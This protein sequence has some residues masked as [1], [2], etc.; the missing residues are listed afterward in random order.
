MASNQPIYWW[1]W[2]LIHLA[3]NSRASHLHPAAIPKNG[4]ISRFLPKRPPCFFASPVSQNNTVPVNCGSDTLCCFTSFVDLSKPVRAFSARLNCSTYQAQPRT[5]NLGRDTTRPCPPRTAAAHSCLCL[6]TPVRPA[7]PNKNA[8]RQRPRRGGG[9]SVFR[10]P[11]TFWRSVCITNTYW[12]K[13]PF[14]YHR[15][16]TIGKD[17][18]AL[19]LRTYSVAGAA[20]H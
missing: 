10:R 17:L 3:P 2:W 5:Q 1:S 16:H 11:L 20:A 8:S 7:A 13:T 12:P 4:D 6:G 9:C 14:V 15:S 19:A 18:A